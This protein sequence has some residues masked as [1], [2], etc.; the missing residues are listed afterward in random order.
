MSFTPPVNPD[1]KREIKARLL[2]MT[3]RAFELFAGDLLVYIGLQNV[4]VTRYIGDGGIDAHGDLIADSGLVRVPTGVQVKRHRHNVQRSDIDRFIGALGGQFHH[5]IFITTADYAKQARVKAASSPLLRVDTVD[6]EQ[7]ISLMVRHDL[8]LQPS[9]ISTPQLDDDYFL[10]FEAQAALKM[11]RVREQKAIYQTGSA[12]N[13]TVDALPEDDLISLKALSYTLRVDMQTVRRGW[14]ETGKLHPD[15]T[16]WVGTREVYFFRR[17]RIEDIRRQ[18]IRDQPPSSSAEWRQEFLDY[19][20]SRNLT[21]SYKSVMIKAILKL[22]NRSGEVKMEDLVHEFREFYKQRHSA[23]LPVEFG[24]SLLKNPLTV[25]DDQI[26]QLIVR[27]PLD[28]FLIQGFLEYLP[29]EG[30]VR[31]APQLWNELRFYELLDVQRSVEEQ[32]DYYYSHRS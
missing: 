13:M 7:L 25:D 1:I 9:P 32:I 28:R 17:D 3:P 16:Q 12:D 24:V 10:T 2:V 26:R 30:V 11:P 5:G 18:F 21:K 15:I 14:I 8:G 27:N 4:A 19:V 20:R 31:F 6:G 29:Q 23:G 22:V